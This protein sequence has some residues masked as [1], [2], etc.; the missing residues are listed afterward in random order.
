MQTSGSAY[1]IGGRGSVRTFLR[2]AQQPNPLGVYRPITPC[3]LSAQ[4]DE[5]AGQGHVS[6]KKPN[7]LGVYRPITPYPLSA[8]LGGTSLAVDALLRDP[9][10]DADPVL[11][12]AGPCHDDGFA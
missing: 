3:P 5:T 2:V 10:T 9:A 8:T 7:P 6:R 12:Q 11:W 1:D 4:V